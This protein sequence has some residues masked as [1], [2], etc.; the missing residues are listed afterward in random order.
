M[1]KSVFHEAL[2]AREKQNPSAICRHLLAFKY[3]K[4]YSHMLNIPLLHYAK[5]ETDFID[6]QF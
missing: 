2:T 4:D 1:G 6:M 5:L 3:T